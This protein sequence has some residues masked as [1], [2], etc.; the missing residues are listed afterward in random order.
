[1]VE[2]RDGVNVAIAEGEAISQFEM[3]DVIRP[4][5]CAEECWA[6]LNPQKN[7]RK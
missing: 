2:I 7:G 1:M 4:L 6:L 3:V 5:T